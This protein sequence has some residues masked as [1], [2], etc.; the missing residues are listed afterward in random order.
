MRPRILFYTFL[1][2]LPILS[3]GR[4]VTIQ[5]I[6]ELSPLNKKYEYVFPRIVYQANKAVAAKINHTLVMDFLQ[7]DP[8]KVRKSI[9][10]AVWPQKKD[11]MPELNG[12]DWIVHFNTPRLFSIAIG[13]EGCAA[14]CEYFTNYYSFDLKTGKLLVLDQLFTKDGLLLLRDSV[15]FLKKEKLQSNIKTHQKLLRDTS[16]QLTTD[17]LESM[18]NIIELYQDCLDKDGI[19]T[20]G[21][22]SFYLRGDLFIRLDRCSAH[23]N[24]SLDDLGDFEFSFN[25]AGL[26][27]YLTPYGRQLFLQ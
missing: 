8:K 24:R 7:I 3:Y 12:L 6:K 5:E 9:F 14:Y 13:A 22:C 11:A 19:E 27:Q 4:Q 26:K 17:D 10:E 16:L 18:K 23:Y 20:V 21:D 15:N 1:F 2:L 25:C